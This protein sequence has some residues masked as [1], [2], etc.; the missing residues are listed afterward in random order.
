VNEAKAACPLDD[1]P[2]SRCQRALD[3]LRSIRQA[4]HLAIDGVLA[5]RRGPHVDELAL[6]DLHRSG[7]IRVYFGDPDAYVIDSKRGVRR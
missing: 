1:L 7:L 5:L 2:G 4:S 3:R 6:C